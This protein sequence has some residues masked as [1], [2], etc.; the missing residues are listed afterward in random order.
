[1]LCHVTARYIGNKMDL[2]SEDPATYNQAEEYFLLEVEDPSL[3]AGISIRGP[4]DGKAV[5][6]SENSTYTIQ[7]RETSNSLVILKKDGTDKL[8]RVATLGSTL[9]VSE[10]SNSLAIRRRLAKLLLGFEKTAVYAG[11]QQEEVKKNSV[12]LFFKLEFRV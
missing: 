3:L 2:Y 4:A 12:S 8:T 1:M 11:S 6:V 9:V 7:R 10:E 5:L